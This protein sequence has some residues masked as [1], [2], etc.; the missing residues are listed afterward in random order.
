MAGGAQVISRTRSEIWPSGSPVEVAASLGAAVVVGLAVA[1]GMWVVAA[2]ILAGVLVLGI[3][4]WRFRSLLIL[5]LAGMGT[6]FVFPNKVLHPIATVLTVERVLFAVLVTA[7]LAGILMRIVRPA[8]LERTDRAMLVV[9]AVCL[10]SLLR[11]GLR[12]PLPTLY[13][14][15]VLWVEGLLIPF[16][17]FMLAKN[18]VWGDRE[19]TRL[20]KVLFGV[21]LYLSA[22]GLLQYHAGITVFLPTYLKLDPEMDRAM[23]VFTSPVEYGAV[24]GILLLVTL[25]QY[26]RARDALARAFLLAGMGVLAAGI[27][28]S[29]TRAVWIAVAAAMVVIWIKDRRGRA[30]VAV[31]ALLGGLWLIVSSVLLG[32]DLRVRERILEAEPLYNRVALYSTAINIVVHNP[33]FGLG[34]GPRSF[35]DA[36]RDYYASMGGVSPQWAFNPSLPHNELLFMLVLTGLVGAI[37]YVLVFVRGYGI[38]RKRETAGRSGTDLRPELAP[39][40]GAMF[41]IGVVTALA[42]DVTFYV[43]FRVLF[44]FLLGVL[45]AAPGPVPAATTRT[46]GAERT[47]G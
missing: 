17:A 22:A 14:G 6:V 20:L 30:P 2:L 11:S 33:M 8:P 21:G 42:S 43:Y 36:K 5:W 46:G 37:P 9:L 24:L 12:A 13:A 15:A 45:A 25:L 47:A 10:L 18:Q 4:L 7:A 1:S 26:V 3:A 31:G 28:A 38:V 29:R 27:A 44:F 23:G 19:L 39:Y 35:A 40:V 34:W 16:G 32:L 41:A